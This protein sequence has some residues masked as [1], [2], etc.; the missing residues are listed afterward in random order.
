MN[1]AMI[2]VL[3][4]FACVA[5]GSRPLTASADEA[6]A[7]TLRDT[8][9]T[10][11]GNNL[12]QLRELF[13]AFSAANPGVKV[14]YVSL[15]SAA[16]YER[17]VSES[18]S[19]QGT[20]DLVVSSGMDLQVK[21]V[22]DGYAQSYEAP[23]ASHLPDWLKWQSMAYGISAEP[24]VI[25]YN[26]DL[27]PEAEAPHSHADLARLLTA[28][29]DRYRGKVATF[30]VERSSTGLLFAT[31]DVQVTSKSWDLFRSMGQVGVKVYAAASAMLDRV[32]A[33][34]QY[35]AYNVIG[36]YAFE[37]AR[38]QPSLGIIVPGDYVLLMSRIAIIPKA[39][40]HPDAGRQLLNF[41]L[42]QRGQQILAAHFFGPVRDD[43]APVEETRPHGAV[44]PIHVGPAL[45]TYLDQ[46]KSAK[47][48]QE[49]RR[50]LQGG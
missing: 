45:L 17:V 49:W 11:Y 19:A 36:S 6:R 47:F 13:D 2:K 18:A 34:D 21:L 48:L 1:V 22:N 44:I 24:I 15:A 9:V 35:I 8:V 28:E 4:A 50:A 42:S 40:R 23:D 38:S 5:I 31:Q 27:V 10:V 7:E 33:G 30:D 46:A 29:T 41:I 43:V 3:L 12:P 16:Q 14:D 26:K 32:A 20:A 37:R 39:A 25:V